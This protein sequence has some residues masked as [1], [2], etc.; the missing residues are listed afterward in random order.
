VL[1]R[2]D[3]DATRT[4][5]NRVVI[6]SAVVAVVGTVVTISADPDINALGLG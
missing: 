3:T 1:S 4:D 2:A 5:A 6:P